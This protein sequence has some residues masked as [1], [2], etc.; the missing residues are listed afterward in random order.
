MRTHLG[1][2]LCVVLCFLLLIE[3]HSANFITTFGDNE[4]YWDKTPNFQ[5]TKPK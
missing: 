4:I 1:E 3:R 5:Q 2:M